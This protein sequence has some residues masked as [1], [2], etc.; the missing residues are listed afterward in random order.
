MNYDS[1][2]VNGDGRERL[3]AHLLEL[4]DRAMAATAK[5]LPISTTDLHATVTVQL[6][7]IPAIILGSAAVLLKGIAW[8][9]VNALICAFVLFF[10]FR[11]GRDLV[12]RDY[13]LLPLR[14]YQARR[15]LIGIQE[16]L[17]AIVYGTLA[18]AVLQGALTG[19]GFWILGGTSPVLDR[20]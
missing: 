3:G 4:S 14:I 20:K 13:V 17:R 2:K 15:L 12:R 5:Y 11:D 19:I 7:R 6:Q 18:F 10:L 9:L 1:L 16:T 8:G